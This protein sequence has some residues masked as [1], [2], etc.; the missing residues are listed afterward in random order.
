[1][2]RFHAYNQVELTD[3]GPACLQMICAYH[4]KKH[5]LNFIKDGISISRIGVT[6]GDIKRRGAELGLDC[7]VI[8]AKSDRLSSQLFPMILHWRNNHFVVLY[9]I[10]RDR[11][12]NIVYYIADPAVGKVRFK[13]KDFN[14]YWLS[15]DGYGY[16]VIFRP[17]D[18]F[19]KYDAQKEKTDWNIIR[20]VGSKYSDKKVKI[21]LY[22]LLLFLSM[23]CGW[24]IPTIYQQ[25][26]D[27]GVMHQDISM[28][29]KLFL[30][31]LSFFIGYTL[32]SGF[33]TIIIS[34]VN[35][36]VGL[37]YLSELLVKIIKLPIKYFDTTLNTEFIERFD[38][39]IRLRIFLT[40]NAVNI[41]IAFVNLIIYGSLLAYYNWLS[42]FI[43]IFLSAL[44]FIWGWWFLNKRKFYDYASFTNQAKNRNILHE[45]IYGMQDI[46]SNN[47]QYY[48]VKTWGDN[49]QDINDI[50]EKLLIINYKQDI[51]ASTMNKLRDIIIIFICAYLTIKN[52]LSLGI[53]MS[54]SYIL[55]QLSSPIQQLQY[56]GQQLQQAKI[57]INRLSAVQRKQEENT[58]GIAASGLLKKCIALENV[59]FKYEG[60]FSPYIFKDLSIV[61]PKGKTTAIVGNSGSGKTTLLKLLLEFYIP[62]KGFVKVDDIDLKTVDINSWRDICGT[63]LQDG[64]IF[65]GSIA[66]NIALGDATVDYSRM[67]FAAETA[68]IDKFIESMPG[69]YNMKIG[70]TGI[71]LSQ[72]QKQ[73]ILIA[74]AVYRNPE[75]IIFDEAT[76]SLDTINEKLIM[77]NL[78]SFF[79]GRT[80]IIVAHRLSTVVNADNIIY[81]ENGVVAE[82][83]TH[84]ELVRHKGKYYQLIKNQLEIESN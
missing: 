58:D 44:G 40:N 54:I 28:V 9:K 51:G 64:R 1:M 52:E 67:R 49:Q 3:C 55:G 42:L 30:V 27:K 78:Y 24:V 74:R 47:A 69:K 23:A 11:K 57:S 14:N 83:G 62:Q 15:A 21:S 73:R 82:Q 2:G 17:T 29:Y 72:G 61:F 35:F 36:K 71:E 48:M 77:D 76:S 4:G 20:N 39:F 38:D 84:K 75:L 16:A 12:G 56:L 60:S 32:S 80:L 63:V 8:K 7:L 68:C 45:L 10:T 13:S 37:E 31:Q 53:L 18:L 22:F 34:K 6:V 26:I 70:S 50:N 46:K 5:S 79:K 66:D 81:L 59:W 33:S 65:C 25:I 41:I 43:Y 19:F